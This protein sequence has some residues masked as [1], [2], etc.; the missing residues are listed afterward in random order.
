MKQRGLVQPG[1]GRGDLYVVIGIDI[2]ESLT[3]EQKK[4]WEHLAQLG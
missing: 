2:P 4:A 1:G 3:P